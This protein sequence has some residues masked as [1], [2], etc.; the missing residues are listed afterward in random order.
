MNYNAIKYMHV[1]KFGSDEVSGIEKCESYVL[2]KIDGTNGVIWL[3]DGKIHCGSR[4]RE[5]SADSDNAGFFATFHD[6]ERFKKLFA[7]YPRIVVY[8]E[9]LVKNVIKDYEDTA[10]KKFYVF[11]VKSDGKWLTPDEYI[12]VLTKYGIDFIPYMCK[13]TNPTIEQLKDLCEK[14]SFL[15]KGGKAGEGIVLHAPSYVN[16]FGRTV[17]AK[18]VRSEFKVT[19]HIG[20]QVG[21]NEIESK[22]VEKYFTTALINKEYAKI[23]NEMGGWKSEYIPRFLGTTY[24]T[25]IVEN[26]WDMVKKNPTINFS[27]L[28]RLCTEKMK[29]VMR[30]VF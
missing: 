10:W 21:V 18:V 8:G 2:P 4:K 3:E 30:S 16:K 25:F 13:I 12:P 23:V 20:H 17:W 28:H 15:M 1:E 29:D 6:D 14:A 9:Y 22:M 26:A 24:H 27:V 5:L 19:K 7:E 11:D